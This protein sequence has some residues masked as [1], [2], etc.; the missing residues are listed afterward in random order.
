MIIEDVFLHNSRI[1]DVH[2]IEYDVGVIT[3]TVKIAQLD[4]HVVI[5]KQQATQLIE[6]LQ[7][8]VNGEEIE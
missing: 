1:E 7:R 3:D 6:V 2:I 4:D 5:S 8:W